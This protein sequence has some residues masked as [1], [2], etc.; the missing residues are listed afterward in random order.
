[1]IKVLRKISTV[2]TQ[3]DCP[4]LL[5]Y[6]FPWSFH[7][8]P[9]S[10]QLSIGISPSSLAHLSI[11]CEI[12]RKALPKA[13][14]SLVLLHKKISHPGFSY[15]LSANTAKISLS[16]LPSDSESLLNTIATHLSTPPKTSLIPEEKYENS[17]FEALYKA[18]FELSLT[19]TPDSAI[20][21]GE[22][23]IISAL[24]LAEA[25]LRS[26]EQLSKG[27]PLPAETGEYKPTMQ[28]FE[29]NA[30]KVS[31]C[32]AYLA[33]GLRSSDFFT[34]K[35]LEKLMTTDNT[36]FVDHNKQFN[37]LNS[38]LFSIPGIYTHKAVYHS[39]R[40]FGFFVHYLT[41]HPFS[42]TFAGSAVIKSMKRA[43]RNIIPK[44]I[45]RTQ[46]ALFNELLAEKNGI[47]L[48]EIRN[49][50][51]KANRFKDEF[52][53]YL[54]NITEEYACSRIGAWIDTKFPS[55]LIQG[56]IVSENVIERMF[57]S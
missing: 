56:N 8:L 18:C 50:S 6:T 30:E 57:D 2:A 13:Q 16:C 12:S 14:S 20:F 48:C 25:Q 46:T 32:I 19:Q 34:F 43:T 41:T 42:V 17:L 23:T 15:V 36:P 29:S 7:K 28:I 31:L 26:F 4:D 11:D 47:Q 38:L 45:E 1:M 55:I 24:N 33:P 54:A 40:N 27:L 5:Q 21:S 35:F 3:I 49:E 44:E 10:V 9:N 39:F 52:P 22:N 51:V 37:Y 53:D